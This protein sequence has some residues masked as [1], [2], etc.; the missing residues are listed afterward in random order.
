MAKMLAMFILVAILPIGSLAQTSE[1]VTEAQLIATRPVLCTIESRGFAN[2]DITV[3]EAGAVGYC[4]VLPETAAWIVRHAVTGGLLSRAFLTFSDQPDAWK[5]LLRWRY[6]NEAIADAYL[7]W[8]H[9][10]R[11]TNLRVILYK[12]HAGHNARVRRG[13]K[14]WEHSTEVYYAMRPWENPP[15]TSVKHDQYTMNK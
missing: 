9:R 12:Y 14:S 4:Q 15:R 8:M 7:L 11:S 5:Y 2:P 13:T 3:S 6:V 1:P 10:K